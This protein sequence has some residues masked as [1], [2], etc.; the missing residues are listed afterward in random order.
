MTSV[1]LTVTGE[2]LS[3][4]GGLATLS[5]NAL[6]VLIEAFKEKYALSDRVEQSRFAYK[7]Y[8]KVLTTIRGHLRGLPYNDHELL[9]QLGIIDN[10][11]CDTCAQPSLKAKGR[12]AR[13]YDTLCVYCDTEHL[14]PV[15]GAP[16][17]VCVPHTHPPKRPLKT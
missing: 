4:L 11:I 6:G 14:K 1:F 5:I 9:L 10:I 13:T 12:Y 16:H 7:S 8:E 15:D 2:A 17:E 3:L